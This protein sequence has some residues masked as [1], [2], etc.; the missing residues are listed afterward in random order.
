MFSSHEFSTLDYTCVNVKYIRGVPEDNP[1]QR[2]ADLQLQVLDRILQNVRHLFSLARPASSLSCRA[3]QAK[4]NAIKVV[5]KQKKCK[6]AGLDSILTE[7]YAYG[8]CRLF[9]H[10]IHISITCTVYIIIICCILVNPSIKSQS[11]QR[12]TVVRSTQ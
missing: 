4:I 8:G 6:A 2:H 1:L 7:A 12:C 5:Q 3:V 10:I 11:A 9:V